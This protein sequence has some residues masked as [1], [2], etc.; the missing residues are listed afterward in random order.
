MDQQSICL[1]LAMKRLSAQATDSKLVAVLGPDAIGYSTVTNSF[2]QWHFPS[3]LREITAW[4]S[5]R[6]LL[7]VALP[8]GRTFNAEYYCD[9]VLAALTLLQP[10]DDEKKLVV[11]AD[12]ARAHTAQKCRTFVKKMDCGSLPTYPTHLISRHPISFCSVMSRNFSK[13]WCFH[14]TKNYSTQLVK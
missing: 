1:F 5:L 8:K 4:N 12:N 11:H 14:Y 6:F 2:R 3:P 9:N 13:E 7:I 10:E